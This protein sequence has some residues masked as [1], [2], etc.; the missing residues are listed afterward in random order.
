MIESGILILLAY[1]WLF[2]E[3]PEKWLAS[4]GRFDAA[5]FIKYQ[6][7]SLD[8][9]QQKTEDDRMVLQIELEAFRYFS[10]WQDSDTI[11]L[12]GVKYKG[13]IIIFNPLLFSY[14]VYHESTARYLNVEIKQLCINRYKELKE[15]YNQKHGSN[16]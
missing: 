1:R 2:S 11:E 15:E 12:D 3:K 16:F 5:E 4:K 13:K 7:E 14:T 8:I 9:I 10:E 6:D